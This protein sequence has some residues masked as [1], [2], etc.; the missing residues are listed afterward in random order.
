MRSKYKHF[1]VIRKVL[2]TA[3]A[4]PRIVLTAASFAGCPDFVI[5]HNK[6]ILGALINLS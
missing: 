3:P 5:V 1:G 2:F 4:E 6:V